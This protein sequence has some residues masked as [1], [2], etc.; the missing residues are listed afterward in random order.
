MKRFFISIA[1]SVLLAAGVFPAV[2]RAESADNPIWSGLWSGVNLD[3]DSVLHRFSGRS[4]N[5]RPQSP[6]ALP[7]PEQPVNGQRYAALGDSVAAGLGLPPAGEDQDAR[8]G[9]STQAYPYRVAQSQGLTLLHLA[10]SGATAGDLIT[11][12]RL[13]GPNISPQLEAAFAGGTPRL[14][15]IT[16]G[17][18]DVQWANSLRFCYASD[19]GSVTDTAA[20]N[21]ALAALQLKYQYAMNDIRQRSGGQPPTVIV[22]G[23]YNPLSSECANFQQNI[24]AKELEWLNAAVGALNQTIEGVVVMYPFARF[25]PIDFTGH[26]ICSG[27]PWVQGLA[28][29]APFHPTEEG[30]RVIAQSVIGTLND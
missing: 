11:Q 14:I 24:T 12:Q 18:N 30:Q 7:G 23:Y 29:P 1:V 9:R 19:C 28:D 21:I 10:C 26:S 5:N 22:T 17:A 27:D 6:P 4:D 20:I 8:C 2:A 16:A 13:N 25:V 15:T 3:L